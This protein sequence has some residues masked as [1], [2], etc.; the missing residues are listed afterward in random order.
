[1]ELD[2]QNKYVD[3]RRT[4]FTEIFREFPKSEQ[5][6]HILRI[7]ENI[8]V[9]PR[10]YIINKR[11]QKYFWSYNIKF[12]IENLLPSLVSILKK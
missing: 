12:S 6:I 7:I 9:Q 5:Q 2:P 8:V 3:F 4:K 1:M 10:E 11:P